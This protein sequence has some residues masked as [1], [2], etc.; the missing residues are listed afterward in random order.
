MGYIECTIRDLHHEDREALKDHVLRGSTPKLK[1]IFYLCDIGLLDAKPLKGW[2]PRDGVL[3][4]LEK[5]YA[6]E[7]GLP[8]T[9]ETLV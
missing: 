1:R 6:H 8:L 5:M 3:D 7:T 4:I 2:P 9:E